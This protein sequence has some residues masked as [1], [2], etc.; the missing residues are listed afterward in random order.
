MIGWSAGLIFWN[1]GG[2]GMLGGSARAAAAIADWTSRAAPSK[3]RERLNWSVICVEPWDELEFMLSSP[4]IVVNCFSSGVATEEAIVTGE[5]PG[6]EAETW[7]VGK[8]T[9]GRSE[10]GSSR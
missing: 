3:L 6:R 7:I 1:D 4:A 2:L 9:L 5:A 8:S 10:I